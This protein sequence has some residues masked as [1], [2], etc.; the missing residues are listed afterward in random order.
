MFEESTSITPVEELYVRP[1]F[2]DIASIEKD[3]IL[4]ESISIVRLDAMVPPPVKP[5]PAIIETAV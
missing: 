3:L 2:P 1:L 4:S 5:F